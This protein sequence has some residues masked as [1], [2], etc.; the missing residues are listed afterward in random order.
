MCYLIHIKIFIIFIFGTF[1][2]LFS[3]IVGLCFIFISLIIVSGYKFSVWRLQMKLFPASLNPC[4]SGLNGRFRDYKL[5]FSKFKSL[6][7]RTKWAV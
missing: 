7:F 5:I 2:S 4:F 6:F 3:I 1:L